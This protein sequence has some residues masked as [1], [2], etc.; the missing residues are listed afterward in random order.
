MAFWWSEQGRPPQYGGETREEV[1]TIRA[2]MC[3][4]Y[5]MDEENIWIVEA[6]TEMHAD[7]RVFDHWCANPHLFYFGDSW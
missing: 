3:S 7:A 6:D 1:E 4:K 2:A 5:S